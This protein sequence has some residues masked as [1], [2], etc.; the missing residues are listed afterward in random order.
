VRIKTRASGT[1]ATNASGCF[2]A[3]HAWHA[4]VHQDH[5]WLFALRYTDSFFAAA[6]SPITVMSGW[7]SRTIRKPAR[8][9]ADRQPKVCEWSFGFTHLFQLQTSE[10][11]P[12]ARIT[13][14]ASITPLYN[15]T[16]SFMP[17]CHDR[18]CFRLAKRLAVS[19][20]VNSI[21]LASY[22]TLTVASV[23]SD[24]CLSVLVSAS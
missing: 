20:I 2:D 15:S 9:K 5:I 18:Q 1:L 23:A 6:R 19:V 8:S 10:Y 22:F 11:S 14:P 16:R 13:R 7:A 21:A 4:N 12:A 3:V 24:A 17:Q